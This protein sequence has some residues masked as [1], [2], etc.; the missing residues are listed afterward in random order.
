M[1][2]LQ[3]EGHTVMTA[4]VEDFR[5]YA[6]QRGNTAPD[7]ASDEDATSA[8]VRAG[9]HITYHYVRRFRS[10]VTV[11]ETD[12]DAATYEAAILELAAPGFFNKTFTPAEQKV[13]TKV[14]DIEWQ[15]RG[16]AS[17]AEGATPV[18]TRINDILARYMYYP[19]GG[20]VV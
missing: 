4:T 17:G 5:T 11:D 19:I 3:Y 6:T 10:T 14:G 2:C 1:A 16:N 8:L 7:D 12:L 13:L 18:S 9:D 20:F 15:V